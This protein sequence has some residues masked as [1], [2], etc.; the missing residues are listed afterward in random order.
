MSW[1]D[2]SYRP[3]ADWLACWI[4]T[5]T[6]ALLVKLGTFARDTFVIFFQSWETNATRFCS[7]RCL[8]N[9]TECSAQAKKFREGVEYS[10]VC[11]FLSMDL[12]DLLKSDVKSK[13]ESKVHRC[14]QILAWHI[15]IHHT[16]CKSPKFPFNIF[17]VPSA[18]LLFDDVPSRLFSCE[19]LWGCKD[20]AYGV[21]F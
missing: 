12:S 10:D 2:F 1:L 7:W 19:M 20:S 16:T 6:E 18:V 5:R 21:P 9:A 4:V 14:A 15:S 17:H 3:L 8:Q 11:E 13:V